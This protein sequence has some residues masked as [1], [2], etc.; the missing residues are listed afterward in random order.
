MNEEVTIELETGG[1]VTLKKEPDPCKGVDMEFHSGTG[2]SHGV[3]LG[4][5][6]ASK[7]GYTL[8]RLS[9]PELGEI[10]SDVQ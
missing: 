6:D 1:S 2:H 3:S 4:S 5:S 10:P 9:H 7:I 8:V